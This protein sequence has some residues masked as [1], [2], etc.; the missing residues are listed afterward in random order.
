M[1]DEVK[2]K[3][4]VRDHTWRGPATQFSPKRIAQELSRAAREFHLYRD[5]NLTRFF[6]RSFPRVYDP[7]NFRGLRFSTRARPASLVNKR[8]TSRPQE[9]EC[10]GLPRLQ[11]SRPLKLLEPRRWL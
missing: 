8:G 7:T 5:G 3:F 4:C 1:V 6:V 2:A 9:S 11:G 10:G